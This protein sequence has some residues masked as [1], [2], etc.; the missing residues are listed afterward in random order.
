MAVEPNPLLAL[1]QRFDTNWYLAIATRGY[2]TI[3][4]DAHFPP[5]YPAL[6]RCLGAL[7]GNYLVAALIVS[8]LALIAALGVFYQTAREMGDA[9]A[10]SRATAYLLLFPTAFF[11]FG[12]YTEPLFLFVALLA[13]RTMQKGAW[14]RTGFLIFCAILIRLQGVALL[15]PLVYV[16][17]RARPFD[18]KMA[19]LVSLALPA[20][21]IALYLLVRVAG[22]DPALIPTAEANLRARLA[23]PWENYFYALQT[24]A[25]ARFNLADVLNFLT[26]TL[27]VLALVF[28]WRRLPPAFALYAAASIIV[29]TMRLVE[30][31]PLNSMSRYALTLFPIFVLLGVWSKSGWVQRAIVYP[32]FALALY[33]SAQFL[34]WGWVG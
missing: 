18:Q 29:L 28:G 17:W 27:F 12:A 8:N 16:V 2:G 11:F 5:L 25:S 9:G 15:V 3:V 23:P 21:A 22:G 10:A 20:I 14:L 33:L 30:M 32:S 4:G 19:R 1:W 13:L 31:Q 7:G 26:T 34:M 24:F 6:I